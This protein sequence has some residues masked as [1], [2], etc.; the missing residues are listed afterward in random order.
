MSKLYSAFVK[1]NKRELMVETDI[2]LARAID[3]LKETPRGII[4]DYDGITYTQEELENVKSV[5]PEPRDKRDSYF[6]S[7][8]SVPESSDRELSL[9]SWHNTE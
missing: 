2:P 5:R 3:F 7:G 6:A 8:D 9:P 4:K 1:A